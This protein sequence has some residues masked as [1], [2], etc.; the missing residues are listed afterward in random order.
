RRLMQGAERV[1]EEVA[2]A[3]AG[4]GMAGAEGAAMGAARHLAAA[5]GQAEGRLEAPLE[6]LDRAAEALAEA[7]AG[8]EAAMADFSFDPFDLERTEE[9]LFALR[10]LARKHEC[11]PDALSALAEEMEAQLSRIEAGSGELAALRVTLATTEAAHRSAVDT[12]SAKRRAAAAALDRAVA[13][14]LPALKM[15]RA[16]FVTEVT[17]VE[18]GPEGADQIAFLIA[19]NPGAPPAPL[20]RVASGGELS[21]LLLALKVALSARGASGVMIFDEIDRGVGGATAD[22]VGRRLARLAEGAQVLVVTHSP[23][24]AAFGAAQFR[25][26]KAVVAGE[27]RTEVRRLSAPEREEEIAR[28]LAGDEVTAAARSAAA[29]LLSAAV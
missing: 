2:R 17:A 13:A 28:M 23:Q 29:A 6:A 25:I 15:E 9:R 21:R 8:V 10:A 5:A 19:A 4:L 16:I 14:E 1:R 12:L 22:A 20:A 7:A 3:D 27:T 24:V 11:A 26:E 18:P